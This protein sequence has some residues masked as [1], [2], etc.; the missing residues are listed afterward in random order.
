MTF[1]RRLSGQL[2]RLSPGSLWGLTAVLV[3]CVLF[4]SGVVMPALHKATGDPNFQHMDTYTFRPPSV[5]FANLDALG[6]RGIKVYSWGGVFDSL[7]PATYSLLFGGLLAKIFCVTPQ[8]RP[9][10][11]LPSLLSCQFGPGNAKPP[12]Q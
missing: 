1:L 10:G 7:V 5:T 6:P 12:D 4:F 3:G 8:Q 2:A 11:E 9:H